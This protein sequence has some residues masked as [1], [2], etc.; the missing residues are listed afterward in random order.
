MNCAAVL[1]ELEAMG[2]AQHRKVYARHGVAPPLFG[3]SYKNQGLLA[4]KLKCNH[5]LAC[6]LWDSGNHDARVLATMVADPAQIDARLAERWVKDLGNYVL[7][8]AF[9]KLI[10]RTAVAEAKAQKWL[11]SKKEWIGRAGWTIVAH[12]AG[13]DGAMDDAELLALLP[14]I[15]A[16][17]HTAPNRV[18]DAMNMALISIGVRNA[19]LRRAALASAKRIGKVEVDH[20]ATG[21]KTPD[22]AD[23]I[24]KTV[25]YRQRK[26]AAR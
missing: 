14:Q 21:C 1:K 22:A 8:D 17:I 15:E 19:K 11:A 20:G 13:S 16:R 18:R 2:T 23:Y 9:A 5:A 12:L 6:E 7:C 4:K 24:A 3:V 26:A 10:A 25:A